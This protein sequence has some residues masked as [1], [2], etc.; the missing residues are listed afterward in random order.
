MAIN[1]QAA[2][3]QFCAHLGSL[4]LPHQPEQGQSE[5]RIDRL[6]NNCNEL[7]IICLG[8]LHVSHSLLAYGAHGEA[9]L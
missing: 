3:Q 8:A 9:W 2:V 6:N 7:Y 4:S 1:G 5:H